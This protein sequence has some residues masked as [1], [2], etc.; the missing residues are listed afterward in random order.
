MGSA[1]FYSETL[2]ATEGAR[3]PLLVV[4]AKGTLEDGRSFRFHATRN[5][6]TGFRLVQISFGN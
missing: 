4:N 1:D 3:V 6:S 5:F 2:H